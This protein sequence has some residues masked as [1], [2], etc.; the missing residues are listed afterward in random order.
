M[1]LRR[2]PF[3]ATGGMSLVAGE[4]V[5]DIALARRLATD[6][7]SVGFLDAADL[8]TVRMF[9]SLGDA[10]TG[11][12]RSLAF[13][14]SNHPPAR[15]STSRWCSSRR[16]SRSLGCWSGAATSSTSSCLRHVSGRCR[17]ADGL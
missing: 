13:P 3:L 1:T 7:W 4:V 8:L 14:V 17:H 16:R 5:E 11:W 2:D 9:E 12:G 15:C 6:G 10:W